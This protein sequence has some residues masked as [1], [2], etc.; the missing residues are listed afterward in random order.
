MGTN[1]QAF[2]DLGSMKSRNERNG[3]VKAQ[4]KES[5]LKR[6]LLGGPPKVDCNGTK[7]NKQT[8]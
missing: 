7:E 1:P 3:K 8:Y 2:D 6:I 4:K 5:G